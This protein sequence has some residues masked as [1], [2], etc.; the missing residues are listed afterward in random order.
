MLA[1]LFDRGNA[2]Q[3][4]SEWNDGAVGSPAHRAIAREAVRRSLVLLKNEGHVLPLNPHTHVLV[5]GVA[6][7]DI[8]QQC[9]GWTIDWQGDHNQNQDFPGATSIY[10]GIRAAVTAAG[11]SAEYSPDG[12]FASRPDVAVVVFGERPYAEFDGDKEALMLGEQDEQGLA[13]MRQ[14]RDQGI[15]T[16]AVLLTG[17]PL[18]INAELNAANAFVV[19]WLPGSEGG[20]VADVLVADEHGTARFDFRGRLPF[21]WPAM[22]VPVAHLAGHGST[23]ELFAGGYGLEYQSEGHLQKLEEA[24]SGVPEPAQGVPLFSKRHVI[25]PW[26]IYLQ[27]RVGDLRDTMEDVQS[28]ARVLSV[29]MAR[30][31]R[32]GGS[33]MRTRN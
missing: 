16:V 23:G 20:G 6:G 30:G 4:S 24:Q 19:A 27:D 1:G 5:A 33:E 26:S 8:G 11:G 29:T 32:S 14:L 2:A 17:R 22:P 28:Q 18:W 21:D 25:A 15:P 10:S 31:P 13:L 7:D 9:G 12:H 3:R